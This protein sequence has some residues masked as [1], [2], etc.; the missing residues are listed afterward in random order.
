MESEIARKIIETIK[1]MEGVQQVERMN[2]DPGFRHE[3][4]VRVTPEDGEAIRFTIAWVEDDEEA[5][6]F[7][8]NFPAIP[9]AT[10]KF[11]REQ[12]AAAASR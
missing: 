9:K 11:L 10:K 4:L 6:V 5:W 12:A 3:N 7:D 1:N 8:Q 2:R